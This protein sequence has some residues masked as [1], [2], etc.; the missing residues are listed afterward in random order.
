LLHSKGS[1]TIEDQPQHIVGH[2]K[3][4]YIKE[5]TE[6]NTLVFADETPLS[7]YYYVNETVRPTDGNRIENT[8]EIRRKTGR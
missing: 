8:K 2:P 4:E 5:R 1:L 6:E 7:E 3:N